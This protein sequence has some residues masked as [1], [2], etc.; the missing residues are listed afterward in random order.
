MGWT[1]PLLCAHCGSTVIPAHDHSP[2]GKLSGAALVALIMPDQSEKEER[3]L[4]EAT[5]IVKPSTKHFP[6]QW[7]FHF[8]Q[9]FLTGG[10]TTPIFGNEEKQTTSALSNG[11]LLIS[12]RI[13]IKTQIKLETRLR[14]PP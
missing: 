3:Y 2:W 11:P 6:L 9:Q 1:A 8:P 13:R 10:V 7:F 14:L 4:A 12:G 5:L